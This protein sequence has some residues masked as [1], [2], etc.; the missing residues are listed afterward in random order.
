MIC[1]KDRLSERGVLIADGA[2]GTILQAAGLPPGV[3]PERWN[4][5]NP[6]AI[7]VMHQAYV[8]AG[9][10]LILTNTFGGTRLRLEKTRLGDSMRAINLA[11]ARL[12]RK[13]ARESTFV[14]GDIGPIGMLL[15]PLGRLSIEEAKASFAEQAGTLA[16]GGVD[17]ILIET[18][19]DLKEA[20][21]AVQGACQ[22]TNLP[23]LVSM[24]FDTHG[25]TMMGVSPETAA[26]KLWDLG[27]DVIGANCGR[28]LSETLEAVKKMR[29][30]VPEATLLAKPNAGLPH[31]ESGESIYD[32]TPNVM[33][34]Y[35][36]KFVALDVKIFGGCCGSTPEHIRAVA[37]A[38]RT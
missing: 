7:H 30:A 31:V 29:E 27:V 10:D 34:E 32:I 28:S 22:A 4:L 38:L 8:E 25:H 6:E 12:A 20:L 35:A 3:S 33:A 14:L 2:T 1:L 18:M 37:E 17:A 9:S 5:E 21:A 24:S 11:A 36:L 16:E 19:S 13:A 26:V 15:K 23:I